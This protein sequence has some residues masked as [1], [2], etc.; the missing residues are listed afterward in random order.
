MSAISK[1]ERDAL[2]DVFSSIYTDNY[3]YEKFK[4]LFTIKVNKKNYLFKKLSFKIF[5]FY[6][7]NLKRR[8][9]TN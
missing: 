9:L 6:I 5:K 3:K 7:L 2:E 4:S 8:Y 1:Q